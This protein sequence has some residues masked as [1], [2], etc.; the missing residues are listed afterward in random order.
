MT[1]PHRTAA[2]GSAAL[3]QQEHRIVTPRSARVRSLGDPATA[4]EVWVVLHGYGQLAADFL[5]P[6][7]AIAGATRAV[8]APEALNRFYTGKETG[9]GHPGRPVGATWMTR[10]DR[11]AEIADYITYLDTVV[12]QLAAGRPITALGF[13]QGVPT[14]LRWVT[15]GRTPVARVVV[16]AGEIPADLD[17]ASTRA[18]FPAS[19]IDVAYGTRDEYLPWIDL[20]AVRAR[21]A[22]ASLPLREHPFDGGHRLDR[23]TLVSLAGEAHER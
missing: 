14:L 9:G 13:S 22:E 16:W 20:D 7:Q 2:H 11:E 17:L 4:R 3:P 15:M 21:L 12:A 5:Q 1:D 18:R 23:R 8:L 6:F 19:G 10:E